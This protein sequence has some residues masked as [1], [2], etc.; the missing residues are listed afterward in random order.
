MNLFG[1]SV[2]GESVW[3]IYLLAGYFISK[4][5]LKK[6]HSEVLL[7]ASL[8]SFIIMLLLEISKHTVQYYDFILVVVLAVSAFELLTRSEGWLAKHHLIS[9][10][11]TQVSHFS[12]AVYMLHIIVAGMT[13]RMITLA[14]LSNPIGQYF[15]APITVFLYLAFLVLVV[16]AIWII[17]QITEKNAFVRRYLFLMKSGKAC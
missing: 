12:F 2:W 5:L 8:A 1:A 14:G 10:L 16:F 9:S 11:L 4:G 15:S 7:F 3:T 13:C 6:F 17:V